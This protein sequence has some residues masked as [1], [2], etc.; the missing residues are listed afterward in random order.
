MIDKYNREKQLLQKRVIKYGSAQTNLEEVLAHGLKEKLFNSAILDQFINKDFNDLTAFGDRFWR[1]GVN[2]ALK[3]GYGASGLFGPSILMRSMGI[4]TM[5]D[6]MLGWDRWN[7]NRDATFGTPVAFDEIDGMGGFGA[8]SAN[9]IAQNWAPMALSIVTYGAAGSLGLSGFSQMLAATSGVG[10]S[11]GGEREAELVAEARERGEDLDLGYIYTQNL[12]F[13]FSETFSELMFGGPLLKKFDDLIRANKS[14]YKDFNKG[15]WTVTKDRILKPAAITLPS[16]T[17][18]AAGESIN[19][20][21]TNIFSDKPLYEGMKESFFSSFI[22]SNSVI[23]ATGGPNLAGI[24]SRPFSSQEHSNILKNNNIKVGEINNQLYIIDEN[25]EK[26]KQSEDLTSEEKSEQITNLENNKEDILEERADV[27][28]ESQTVFEDIKYSVT[29][30]G[31]KKKAAEMYAGFYDEM[32]KFKGKA[33]TIQADSN[34]T[35]KE[36]KSEIEKLRVE[37]DNALKAMNLFSSTAFFGH[38]FLAMKGS[39]GLN[40]LNKSII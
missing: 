13:S 9:F 35:N 39:K 11:A 36:K 12:A 6:L 10:I 4:N 37:Y 19:T 21:F 5:D 8:Y 32:S 3:V 26:V 1:S 31:I 38:G 34:L 18:D 29:A 7:Q 14:W 28:S 22:L 2:L 16:Q 33:E 24:F 30:R 15:V 27:L 20:A 23:L 17:L 25:L 40:L